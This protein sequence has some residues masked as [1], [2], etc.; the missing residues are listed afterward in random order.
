MHRSP[1]RGIALV[2]ALVAL[3]IVALAMLGALRWQQQL[4]ALAETARERSEAARLAD[5]EIE[6]LRG[7][8]SASAFA[9]LTSRDSAVAG[10]A[11]NAR[12]A[13]ERRLAATERGIRALALRVQWD[14]RAGRPQGLELATLV[15]GQDPRL[16]AALLRAEAAQPPRGFAGRHAAIPLAARSLGNGRSEFVPTPGAPRWVFDDRTG[17]L[18]PPDCPTCTIPAAL[19]LSGTVRFDQSA[20]PN[21]ATARDAALPFGVAVALAGSDAAPVCHTEIVATGADRYARYHCAIAPERSGGWSGRITLVP[22]GWSIGVAEGALRVCRYAATAAERPSDVQESLTHQ[23]FLVIRGELD[24]P[25]ILATDA[26][27]DR[28]T[29]PHQP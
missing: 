25:A 12:F 20:A 24:C 22:R 19:L 4:R 2:E 1:S 9:A 15:N 16:A 7:F 13:I 18:L 10:Q 6:R 23:D 11:S 26:Y 27:V 21:A 28:R 29:V 17:A 3:L 8:A 5:A 14:D